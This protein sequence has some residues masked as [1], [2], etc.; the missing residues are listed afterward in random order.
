[1]AQQVKVVDAKPADWDPKWFRE[2][3]SQM[4]SNILTTYVP[5][6]TTHAHTNTNKFN[7][8][9]KSYFLKQSF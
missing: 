8:F 3:T 2:R 6:E 1:M 5:Q 4:S 7:T 9:L